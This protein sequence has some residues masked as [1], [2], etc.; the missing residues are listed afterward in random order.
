MSEVD[1]NIANYSLSDILQLF[2]IENG[3]DEEGMKKA[4]RHVLMMHPDK[5]NLSK[6]YFLFFSSA[7]R[8]LY[9]V[10]E[11]HKR[12]NED[13]TIKRNYSSVD[14]D[15]HQEHQELWKEL[16][17]K[18]NFNEVF[19]ELF[20][21]L[22]LK[23]NRK[24]GYGDWFKEQEDILQANNLEEMNR[25]IADK[26]KNL[27]SIII[28]NGIN[29]IGGTAGCSLIDDEY[30]NYQAVMFSSL[31]YD[32]LKHAYTE[33]VV[34]VT[35]EEYEKRPKYSGVDH[36]QRTRQSELL[37]TLSTANHHETL[38]DNRT[39]ERMNDMERAYSLA[40]QDEEMQ[41]QRSKITSK[42]LRIT[43]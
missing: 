27:S 35:E 14:I 13:A 28:F 41:K 11:F 40:K 37:E 26:K 36:L 32:D 34:P 21:E 29:D 15:D 12:N 8:L 19:N 3:L 24:D 5:S 38:E 42:L 2:K 16:S 10:Y 9:K 18:N 33:T 20:N 25:F 39:K 17:N 6:E 31:Q 4:K 23:E 22:S 1:L 7:Y 43:H 30:T